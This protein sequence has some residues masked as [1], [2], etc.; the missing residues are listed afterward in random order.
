MPAGT[1]LP[2]PFTGE[3]MNSSLLHIV[4]LCNNTLGRGATITITSNGFPSQLPASPETGNTLY[5]TVSTL[6]EVLYNVALIVSF[7]LG[8]ALSP[9]IFALLATNVHL[10]LVPFGI[11]V[12]SSVFGR[13]IN[14][15]PLQI[16]SFRLVILGI[17]LMVTDTLKVLPGHNPPTTG[18]TVYTIF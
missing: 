1:I 12:V 4:S 11:M 7:R 17:G 6:L 9:I 15:S 5:T 14:S 16:V 13:I 3:M 10:Y 18:V 8:S 2:L